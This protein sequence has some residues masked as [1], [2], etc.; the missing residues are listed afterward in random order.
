MSDGE[1]TAGD[2]SGTVMD[3]R[4]LL[5]AGGVVAGIAGIAGYGAAQAP[6]AEAAAGDPVLAG[7]PR[8]R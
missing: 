4:A 5:R 6:A 7:P 2:G 8:P 1:G 3:R